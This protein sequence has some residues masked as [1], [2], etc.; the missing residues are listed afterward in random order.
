MVS[1]NCWATVGQIGNIKNNNVC[2]KKAGRSRW[3]DKRPS[4]RGSV[5][6]AVDHPH[7]GGEG[8][9]P[10][11]RSRPVTPWGKAALGLRTRKR[12]KYS[13]SLIIRRRK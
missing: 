7:G 13:D 11:G 9:A 8:R 2:L 1:P 5:M 3:L 4:V 12:N 6:N 10:I